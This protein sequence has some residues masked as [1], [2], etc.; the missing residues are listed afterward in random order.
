MNAQTSNLFSHLYTHCVTKWQILVTTASDKWTEI[1]TG[2][3]WEDAYVS[4]DFNKNNTDGNDE[5]DRNNSNNNIKM[6]ISE[7]KYRLY[8]CF[9]NGPSYN[10]CS[11]KIHIDIQ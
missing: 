2:I 5:D 3:E 7:T 11:A 9:Q 8:H 1:S 6:P 10:R 4:T